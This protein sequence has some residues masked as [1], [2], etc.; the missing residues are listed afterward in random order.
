M[1]SLA[2]LACRTESTTSLRSTLGQGV[3]GFGSAL[4]VLRRYLVERHGD[5]LVRKVG[6][7]RTHGRSAGDDAIEKVRI[8]LRHE[9]RFAPTRRASSEVRVRRCVV[10]SEPFTD[11][12][13]NLRHLS[14][15]LVE[16]VHSSLLIRRRKLRVEH[17]GALMPAIRG[18]DSEAARQCPAH[19]PP[20]RC[21]WGRADIA[22][23]TAAA[24]HQE[25]TIPVRGQCHCK[26]DSVRLP[27]L[28]RA[29]IDDT[30]DAAVNG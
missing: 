7:G 15:G 29:R 30:I 21:R 23:E 25:P 5:P 6:V 16:E 20:R 4:L 8:P 11:L 18:D 10:R 13:A 14:N 27:V 19:H 1:P 17:C 2:S 24:L 22:V 3:R 12:F 26:A 28:A 9:H